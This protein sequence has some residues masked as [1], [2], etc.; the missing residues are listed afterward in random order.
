MLLLPS[1]LS[2]RE[3]R[4]DVRA[5]HV[6]PHCA[7]DVIAFCDHELSNKNKAYGNKQHRIGP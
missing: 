5:V 6:F 3:I 1:L 2:S 7:S 4:S